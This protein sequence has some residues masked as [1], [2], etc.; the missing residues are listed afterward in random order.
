MRDTWFGNP[1]E[2][3]RLEQAGISN[4]VIGNI[5]PVKPFFLRV[6]V[7]IIVIILI[8]VLPR[9]GTTGLKPARRRRGWS[10]LAYPAMS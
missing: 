9:C 6:R 2:S 5:L 4:S 1:K 8:V 10:R 3:A 7:S